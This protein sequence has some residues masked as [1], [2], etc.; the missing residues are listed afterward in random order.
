MTSPQTRDLGS[1]R[2]WARIAALVAAAVA[3]VLLAV[4]PLSSPVQADELRD[5]LAEKQAA[6]K[7]AYAEL[8]GFQNQLNELADRLNTAETRLGELEAEIRDTEGLIAKSEADLEAARLKLEERLVS[9]YKGG[10]TSSSYYLAVLFSESDLVSVLQRFDV[11]TH[12]AEEDQKL[13]DE[14]QGYLDCSKE[15]KRLLEEKKAE[16]TAEMAKITGLQQ[17]AS[18]KL[19]AAKDEY[20]RIKGEVNALEE[21]IRKADAAAAAASAAERRMQYNAAVYAKSAQTDPGEVQPGPFAFPV[22]GPHSYVNS[23]GWPRSGG[24]THQGIDIMAARGTP[25]VACVTGS[26]SSV[27]YSDTGLGGKTVH[28]RGDN[29]NT[30]FYAHLDGIA[31]GISPGVPVT[32]GQT[33]VGYVGNTGNAAG[34]P[35]HLHFEIRV[36]GVPVNPYAT[37]LAS[38]GY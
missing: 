34:G 21:E 32:I 30:Y 22:A 37:L 24:R 33:V 19:T 31:P 23:F 16:Q 28:I 27:C 5:Q 20:D 3:L 11:L 12:I 36:G 14:V 10:M 26:I 9:M 17:E 18:T 2:S 7:A 15:N 35:C 4:L 6:L 13:F 8:D 1:I 29:G 38:E 25:C